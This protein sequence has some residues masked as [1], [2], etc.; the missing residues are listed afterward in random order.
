MTSDLTRRNVIHSGLFAG[1][2]GLPTA[3][4]ANAASAKSRNKL[5]LPIEPAAQNRA[6]VKL[7]GDTAGGRVIWKTRGVIYAIQPERVTPL[8]AMVGSEQS[9]WKQTAADQWLRF[10]STL[11][12]FRD[13][14]SGEWL[15]TFANPLNGK[16]VKLPASFIRHKEG[17]VYT[18]NGRWF[19][20]MKQAFPQQYADAPVNLHWDLAGDTVRIQEPSNFPPILPQPSQ[21]VATLFS[22][23]TELLATRTTRARGEAA[24]WNVF[25][26][27]PYLEMA[28]APGHIL[29]HFDAIKVAAVDDLDP[30]YLERARRFTP[31][32]DQSPELDEGPSFFERILQRRRGAA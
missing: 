3:E 5:A 1:L 9:W 28:G 29:W 31:L 30:G 22:S 4:S 16:T 21:E 7:L 10:P 32:F 23:A 20:A 14:H 13:M 2:A 12:F 6:M 15:E 25:P 8:Y 17:E 11:S 27:H 24:G 18:P 26:W 19:P